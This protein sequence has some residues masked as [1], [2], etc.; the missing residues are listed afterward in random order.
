MIAYTPVLALLAQ[1]AVA[2]TVCNG[3]S[4]LCGK[5][6]SDVTFVGSHDSAFVGTLPVDN[7]FTS[8]ADQLSQ[9]V[10]FLQAQ[11]HTKSGVIELCHTTCAEEDAGTLESYLS[12][13]KTFLDDNVDE[14]VTLLL[15]N[16]DGIAGATFAA[17]FE[18]A[19]IDTYAYSPGKTLSLSQ[20]PTLGSLIDAG[21]RLVV[22]MDYPADTSV[23]YILD[24]FTS[25]IL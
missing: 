19:G 15:T 1:G 14:V 11:T 7:Q 23:S 2:A 8:V 10:R 9:G 4:A 21:T 25:Y 3:Y 20:W 17:A 13:V 12:T 22:F 18:A 6:Y 24:E 16:G 5:L